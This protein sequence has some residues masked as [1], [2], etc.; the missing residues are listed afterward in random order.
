MPI[1]AAGDED[2]AVLVVDDEA[3]IRR[4]LRR[5]LRYEGWTVFEAASGP[6]ALAALDR[7][8][9]DLVVLDIKMPGMDG[10]EVLRRIRAEKPSVAVVMH[11]GHGDIETAVR[12]IQEGAAHFLE[13][14]GGGDIGACLRIAI[15]K[16]RTLERKRLEAENRRLAAEVELHR[17]RAG[18]DRALVGAS[19]VLAAVRERI[20][21]VAP[22]DVRVLIT[23]ESGTGKEVAARLIHQ[24]S[25][26]ATGPFIE[27]NCAAIPEELIESEL[28]GAERG[29]YTG[30][31]R[32]MV[33]KFEQ[34]DGGTI[35]LDEVGDMSARTQAKVLR[36]LEENR[37]TRV[38]GSKS[39]E[40]DVRVLSATNQDL[41]QGGFRSDLLHRLNV[42]PIE[43][44]PLRDRAGD[45]PLLVGH[46]VK[47]LE[48]G[49]QRP[50]TFTEEALEL[51]SRQPFPGNVRELRNLVERLL[52]LSPGDDIGEADVRE[53][54]S[55]RTASG[56]TGQLADYLAAKKRQFVERR[57]AAC[58][59]DRERA[60]RSLGVTPA[61]LEASLA[62]PASPAR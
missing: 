2:I 37:I 54:L 57:V 28:F 31:H 39:V 27:V 21:R 30:A 40:V 32:Q 11:T 18:G 58:D 1:P 15:D 43:M 6:D 5:R 61:D 45:I 56:E 13:K 19:P 12:A 22:S 26:R 60:A 46:F 4:S 3:V 36:A 53:H 34:A 51:L 23:G 25:P 35:F 10:M 62:E 55:G 59:G 44:P 20:E 14:G 24:A 33:G 8:P 50:R 41:E 52:I 49:G 42:I 17:S 16:T 48:A 29:S 47:Q 9:C 7:D 38:G